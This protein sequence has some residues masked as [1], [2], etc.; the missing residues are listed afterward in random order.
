[1]VQPIWLEKGTPIQSM[2]KRMPIRVSYRALMSTRNIANIAVM[3]MLQ[4]FRPQPIH[5]LVHYE[6]LT[7]SHVARTS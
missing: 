7:I 5:R 3:V 4:V 2:P 1:M 6:Y